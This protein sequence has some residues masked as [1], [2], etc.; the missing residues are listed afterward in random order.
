[1]TSPRRSTRLGR[2]RAEKTRN[3]SI[4]SAS[5]RATPS[6]QPFPRDAS[7][8][9]SEQSKVPSP[10]LSQRRRAT[11]AAVRSTTARSRAPRTSS[12]IQRPPMPVSSASLA[13]ADLGRLD[14]DRHPVVVDGQEPTVDRGHHV[15]PFAGDPYLALDHHPE[16]RRVARQDADLTVDGAGTDARGRSVPDLAVGSHELHGQG[17]G[18]PSSRSSAGTARGE[19]VHPCDKKPGGTA[20]LTRCNRSY[21]STGT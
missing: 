2:T 15:G 11:T 1:M 12:G 3:H 16:Q 17:H 5:Y 13:G 7:T 9:R 10:W 18:S 4:R 14:D 19:R 8:V 20:H 21:A 6:R